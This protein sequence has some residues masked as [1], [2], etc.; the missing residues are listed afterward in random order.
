MQGVLK[1]LLAIKAVVQSS[2]LTQLNAWLG[3]G[4]HRKSSP[5]HHD[6]LLIPKN[7][8]RSGILTTKILSHEDRGTLC[9]RDF[10]VR[11][12]GPAS[13]GDA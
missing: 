9:L 6:V 10:V 5:S 3:G 11:F 12:F 1:P 7:I 2:R 8:L 4:L 13:F